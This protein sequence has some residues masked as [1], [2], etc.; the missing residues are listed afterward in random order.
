L[1]PAVVVE[2]DVEEFVLVVVVVVVVVVEFIQK[3]QGEVR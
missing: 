1:P 3:T 2:F